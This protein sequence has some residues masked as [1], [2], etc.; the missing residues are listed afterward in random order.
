MNALSS[1]TSNTL[2]NLCYS[3][4]YWPRYGSN[5]VFELVRVRDGPPG[6]DSHVVR[7]L[8]DGVPIRSSKIN[9]LAASRN[10][11][12]D[13]RGPQGMFFIHDFEQL[14]SKLEEAGG[15]D[16]ASLLGQKIINLR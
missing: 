10:D 3:W 5:L 12:T 6:P 7:V 13:S 14:V 9:G 8:L 2:C 15:Y 11:A 16:Y 1:N 4:R